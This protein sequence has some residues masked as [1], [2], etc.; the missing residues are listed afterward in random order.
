[1]IVVGAC[2]H[3]HGHACSSLIAVVSVTVRA[4]MKTCSADGCGVFGSG[5]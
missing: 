4:L 2:E 3:L 1:V 5:Q